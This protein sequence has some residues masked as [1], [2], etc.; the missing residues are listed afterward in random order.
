M[1]LA[2]LTQ[3]SILTATSEFDRLGRD[4]FLAKYGFGRSR[5][6]FLFV[7]GKRYDSKAIAGAAHGY[8]DGDR[9]PLGPRDFSGGDRTVAQAMRRLG[10]VVVSPA[11]IPSEGVPFEIGRT[12]HRQRD[13]H[14][15]YGGQERG[16][17]STPNGVPYVF[18]FTGDSGGQY[19]YQDGWREDG[20]FDYT[21]EG[22]SGDMQFVRG[23]RAIR[24]HLRDGRDLLLFEALATKGNYRFVG[25]FGCA[26]WERRPAPDRDESQRQALVFQLLPAYGM[27]ETERSEGAPEGASER[28][29]EE[30]RA[31]AY[32]ATVPAPAPSS[33]VRR[34][35]YA[36]SAAVRAYVLARAVGACE[37]CGRAA[38][39]ERSDGTPYLEP[40]HTRRVADGGPDHPKWVGAVCPN[41]H[42]EIHYG[43]G[44][45]AL[46]RKLQDAL[47][48]IEGGPAFRQ[49]PE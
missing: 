15:I 33:D 39:F 17:I 38:P 23:N 46:N 40:H 20:V 41:C 44:G 43:A 2:D 1:A 37:A 42:R 26:G 30:L 19:G 13:I 5:G 24:D 27:E 14:Q 45:K 25:C 16:G 28:T 3:R 32:L 36:R 18:L 10:F 4:A 29:I 7:D 6:Y 34:L 49:L 8:L 48:R 9:K 22:Q 31:A 21:G 11:Q 35:Y 12:Y 47:V